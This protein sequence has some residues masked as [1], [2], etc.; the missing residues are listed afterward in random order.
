MTALAAI[1]DDDEL[2]IEDTSETETKKTLWSSIKSV[3][4]TYFDTIYG[5]TVVNGEALGGSGTA[6]TLAHV[7]I[8]VLLI[9]DGAAV[10]H[11]TTDYT[12]VGTAV[13]FVEAPINPIA[14]YKY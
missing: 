13:T 14:Y 9:F 8:G 7:P 5:I 12:Q 2:V 3:L 10:L 1:A 11:P 4:K 6:R